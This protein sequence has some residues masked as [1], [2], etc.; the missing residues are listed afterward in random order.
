MFCPNCGRN[1]GNERF[2]SGCGAHLL[3]D[4][5][6]FESAV[7]DSYDIPYGIYKDFADRIELAKDVIVVHSWLIFK[8]LKARIRYDQL[9]E[10]RYVNMGNGH[11]RI[12]FAWQ[13]NG[14]KKEIL[15]SFSLNYEQVC[16]ERFF[17]L[18][19]LIKYLSPATVR[20][21]LNIPTDSSHGYDCEAYFQKFHPYRKRAIDALSREYALPKKDAK[22]IIDVEFERRQVEMYNNDPALAVRDMNRVEAERNRQHEQKRCERQESLARDDEY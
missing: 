11:G 2:C 13:E 17:H 6:K 16:Y 19:M 4:A 7:A 3:A 8:T 12:F 22:E 10:V 20:F 15:M 14:I 21:V 9:E 1:C 5:S 18:F